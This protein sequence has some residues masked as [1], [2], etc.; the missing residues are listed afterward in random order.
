MARLVLMLLMSMSRSPMQ[1]EIGLC[2]YRT[3]HPALYRRFSRRTI[4]KR[5]AHLSEYVLCA[6]AFL[7]APP[8]T[9]FADGFSNYTRIVAAD[10]VW[11]LPSTSGLLTSVARPRVCDADVTRLLIQSSAN[12]VADQRKFANCT[13]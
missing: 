4:V 9:S 12:V 7:S 5:R 8:Q 6:R 1:P 11:R 2:Y 10:A 13:R 3:D